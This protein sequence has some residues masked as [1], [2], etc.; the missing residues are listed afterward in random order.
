M[1]PNLLTTSPLFLAEAT[2]AEPVQV[3]SQN[4][5]KIAAITTQTRTRQAARSNQP[6]YRWQI[7]WRNVLAFIYLHTF[8]LYGLYLFLFVCSWKTCWWSKF[9]SLFSILNYAVFVNI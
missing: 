3:I 5:H 6:Q 9:F 1:A 8:A 7:V 2:T 4:A